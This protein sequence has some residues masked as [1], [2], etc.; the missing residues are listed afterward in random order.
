MIA[1]RRLGSAR[2]ASSS[3]ITPCSSANSAAEL[4]DLESGEPAQRH[5][6][7]GVGLDLAQL[8]PVDEVGPGVGGVGRATDDLDHLVDV[9]DG[10]DEAFE[11]V[12][13]GLSL[14]QPEAGAPLHHLHLVVEVVA[15]HLGQIEGA[16]HPVDQRHHVVSEGV[17]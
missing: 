6:E 12:G 14:F 5:V 3:A 13:P 10:D 11:D 1:Q 2:M 8:E 17:L 16:G 15:D 9:V 4:V 7:N